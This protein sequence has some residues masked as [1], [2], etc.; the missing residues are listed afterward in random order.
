MLNKE[1]IPKSDLIVY[2]PYS[3]WTKEQI[4]LLPKTNPIERFEINGKEVLI[5]K[6]SKG[7]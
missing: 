6:I 2:E 4:N 1:S 3:S 7:A 5:Y